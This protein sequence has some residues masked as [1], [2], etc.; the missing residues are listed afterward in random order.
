M[1]S[2]MA[3][4]EGGGGEG[5]SECEKSLNKPVKLLFTVLFVMVNLVN[6]CTGD[7]FSE[8]PLRNTQNYTFLFC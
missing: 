6:T 4:L 8:L 5:V 1:S 7:S 3:R 2:Y